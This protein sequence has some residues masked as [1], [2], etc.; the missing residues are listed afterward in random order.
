MS[1]RMNAETGTSTVFAFIHRSNTLR[2]A[3]RAS[4]SWLAAARSVGSIRI[5]NAKKLLFRPGERAT[6]HIVYPIGAQAAAG[7]RGGID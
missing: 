3:R 1:I 2:A 4:I 5:R 7:D 6:H